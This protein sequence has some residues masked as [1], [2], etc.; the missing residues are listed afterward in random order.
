MSRLA[1]KASI[2]A[3]VSFL[4]F[5][6]T[7]NLLQHCER[8]VLHLGLGEHGQEV[9]LTMLE[10]KQIDDPD[11][12]RLAGA[13]PGP[14]DLPDT[15]RATDDYSFFRVRRDVRGELPTLVFVPVQRPEL[16]EDGAFDDREHQRTIRPGRT[17]R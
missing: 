3:G 1:S 9:D 16:L 8:N 14:T 12:A 15:A 11:A 4:D 2:S 13:W 6:G 10:A 7:A 17:V 5:E